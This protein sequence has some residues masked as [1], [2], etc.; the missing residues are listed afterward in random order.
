MNI[1][2]L[3]GFNITNIGKMNVVIGKN[4]CGKSYLLKKLESKIANDDTY[5]IVRYIS[6]ERGG[7]LVFESG[8][9]Q[10]IATRPTWLSENRRKNQ[11][12]N[13]RQSS[14]S[15]YKRWEI[16]Y[17][18]ETE[19]IHTQTGYVAR[20]FEEKITLINTLLDRVNLKRTNDTF[21]IEQ[22]SDNSPAK[23]DEI[24]SGEA[25]L[26]S[27]GIEVLAFIAEIEGSKENILIIDEPDVHLHP[28]LQHRFANFLSEAIK[29]H[30]VKVILAT[31]STALLS[32]LETQEGVQIFFMQRNDTDIAFSSASE[33][34]ATILPI[35]GAHPLSNVFNKIPILLVEGTDDERVWQQVVRS[36]LGAIKLH[37]CETGGKDKMSPLEEKVNAV[38]CSIY[39]DA[40]AYSLRDRDIDPEVIDDLGVVVRMR[41]SCRAAENLMLTDE[42][43]NS[44]DLNWPQLQQKLHKWIETNTDHQFY[45]EVKSFADEGFMRKE[46]DLKKIRNIIV[47]LMSNKPW[48]VLVGQC[49]A[50]ALT[51]RNPTNEEGSLL[52][53]L[54][55][56]VYSTLSV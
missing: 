19:R 15:L 40:S 34:D 8:V 45:S 10:A 42:A 23:P 4:G 29:D 6:P 9:E 33:I 14:I 52:D 17:L 26:I 44:V 24:S 43:L 5:G 35:F 3:D 18:R 11:S 22:R 25:E 46:A 30:P 27:L 53:F 39:D 49:I 50:S 38:I 16:N 36:S 1:E 20:N 56:K 47:G 54:G 55:E 51:T 7:D 2:N 28:D 12:S 13:F 41:L 31:H 32:G 21:V 48:E 37:P